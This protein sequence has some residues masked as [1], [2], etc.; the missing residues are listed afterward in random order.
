IGDFCGYN[1][2]LGG[3]LFDMGPYWVGDLTLNFN[4][5]ISELA[6]DP[7]LI[8]ELCEGTSWYR[9]RINPQTGEAV[10]QDVNSQFNERVKELARAQT[11]IKGAGRYKIPYANVDN[12]LCLW[13]DGDLVDFG[14]GA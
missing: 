1:A 6:D 14:E 2:T 8:L 12:R 9:C 3:D 13:V 11:S 10:L 5:E 7:E 4:L